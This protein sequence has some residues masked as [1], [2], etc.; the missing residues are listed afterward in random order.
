MKT[1][2]SEAELRASLKACLL[3]LE[4]WEKSEM[5]YVP[6]LNGYREKAIKTARRALDEGGTSAAAAVTDPDPLGLGR[7]V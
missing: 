5:A 4:L 6:G 1:R 2:A 3:T 7:E